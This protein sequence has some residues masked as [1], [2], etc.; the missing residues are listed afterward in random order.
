M[1]NFFFNLK[2]RFITLYC[3]YIGTVFFIF[4]EYNYNSLQFFLQMNFPKKIIYYRIVFP[5]IVFNLKYKSINLYCKYSIILIKFA[6][7]RHCH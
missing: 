4:N 5:K 1:F 6:N 7:A 2:Y 3:K